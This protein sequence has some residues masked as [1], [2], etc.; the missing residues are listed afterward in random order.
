M[1]PTKFFIYIIAL[2]L[3]GCGSSKNKDVAFC[4]TTNKGPMA[5]TYQ[6]Q[7]N[8][9][10]RITETKF[11]YS[12]ITEA[13]SS[14]GTYS[15]GEPVRK[16]ITTEKF[17]E[18]ETLARALMKENSILT[19]RRMLTSILSIKQGTATEMAILR[20]SQKRTQFEALLTT[21]KDSPE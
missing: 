6:D 1:K 18:I 5:I 17:K 10:Y 7:N 9:R 11:T 21:L 12:P 19:T 15:G 8:N 3:L 2:L 16:G 13:E 14:S 20:K 4:G